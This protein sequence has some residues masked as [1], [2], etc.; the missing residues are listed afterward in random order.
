MMFE[1]LLLQQ[2]YSYIKNISYVCLNI[3]LTIYY[4]SSS[5]NLDH[6]SLK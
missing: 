6:E 4:T 3:H 1:D 2:A 5:Y